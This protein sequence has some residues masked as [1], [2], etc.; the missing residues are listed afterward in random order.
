MT[1]Q[2]ALW[3]ALRELV[4]SALTEMDASPAEPAADRVLRY[5]FGQPDTA[6]AF[7]CSHA[8]PLVQVSDIPRDEAAMLR[9]MAET[10]AMLAGNAFFGQTCTDERE[11]YEGYLP[12][13]KALFEANGG[14]NGWAGQASFIKKG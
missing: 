10:L 11:W 7:L 6:I 8:G 2:T 9:P 5:L 1:D 12:E 13:A 14:V 3:D 4:V